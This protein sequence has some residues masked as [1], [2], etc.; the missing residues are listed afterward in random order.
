MTEKAPHQTQSMA[1]PDPPLPV[2][3]WRG[4][5][6]IAIAGLVFFAAVAFALYRW[7]Q[8]QSF[9]PELRFEGYHRFVGTTEQPIPIYGSSLFKIRIRT[10][11]GHEL[12][13][14]PVPDV[15][16]GSAPSL[17][18][19]APATCIEGYV[20]N[21]KGYLAQMMLKA[22][23]TVYLLSGDEDWVTNPADDTQ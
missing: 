14:P 8:L 1:P 2:K 20:N 19:L 7:A 17:R 21:R 5:V 23:G 3:T 15:T 4:T 22:G 10:Q 6:V 11:D 16:G 18:S 13:L 12:T 9:S